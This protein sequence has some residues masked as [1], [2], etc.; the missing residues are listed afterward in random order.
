[1]SDDPIV[2]LIEH[3]SRRNPPAVL[4]ADE[5]LTKWA[6]GY[7]TWSIAKQLGVPE[8][9]VERMLHAHKD[10]ERVSA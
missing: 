8:H 7:D 9:A 3:L 1:M 5:V 10:R 2:S 6:L 4:S